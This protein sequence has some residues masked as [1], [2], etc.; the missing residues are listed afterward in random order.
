MP[1]INLMEFVQYLLTDNSHDVN[2]KES[3]T[4]P[5]PVE[6]YGARAVFHLTREL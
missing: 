5:L 4:V 2:F 3:R 6:R 1:V